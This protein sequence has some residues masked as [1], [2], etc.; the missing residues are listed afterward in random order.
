MSNKIH[1]LKYIFTLITSLNSF[2]HL[3]IYDAL[4]MNGRYGPVARQI[5]SDYQLYY[6]FSCDSINL[7]PYV[8]LNAT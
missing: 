3:I 1:V 8:I 5:L 2:H 7:H 4:V 6:L